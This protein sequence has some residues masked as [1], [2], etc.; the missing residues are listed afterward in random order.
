MGLR[1]QQSAKPDNFKEF[2]LQQKEAGV[3]DRDIAKM[4]YVSEYSIVRWK[5]QEG[6]KRGQ[7]HY[8]TRKGLENGNQN[9]HK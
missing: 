6:F 2:Y 4:L 7:F 1:G 5:R 3:L 8:N 9:K